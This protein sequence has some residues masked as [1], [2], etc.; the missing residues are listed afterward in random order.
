M[1]Q[2]VWS[3][4]QNSAP[5]PRPVSWTPPYTDSSYVVV[6]GYLSQNF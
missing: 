5:P 6:S 4:H 1:D 2:G 3:A